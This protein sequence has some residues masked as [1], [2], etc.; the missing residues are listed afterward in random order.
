[1]S[2]IMSLRP[3]FKRPGSDFWYY[4]IDRKRRS[5][6]TKNKAEAE[7]LFNAIK[8]Q[9]MAGKIL[10]LNDEC[11]KSLGEFIDEFLEWSAD[12]NPVDTHKAH[13]NALNKLLKVEGRSVR[14][15]RVN[16]RAIDRIKA[17]FKSHKP[18]SINNYIRHLKSIFNKPVEWGYLR[19]NPFRHAKQVSTVKAPPLYLTVKDVQ[20]LL[21][22]VD[23]KD[24]RALITAY[25]CTGR[26]RAELTR[27]TWED[28]D[29]ENARYFVRQQKTHLSRWFP[30][31]RDF[32]AVLD[33]FPQSERQGFVFKRW[34]HPDTVSHVVKA[35]LKAAG[36]GRFHLH[37]LRHSFALLFLEQEGSL[38]TLQELLGHTQH[39]T[40]EIYAHISGD[41]LRD[42]VNMVKMPSILRRVK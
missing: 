10:R 24:A 28:V 22:K 18:A 37:T 9:Y 41:H 8:K 26:R 29:M 12:T 39:Q 27:L 5:L 21:G 20:T 34:R 32:M 38:R 17:E 19:A 3:P 4:E 31:S 16:L 11:A 6:G 40:T 36:L 30:A 42:A 1:M 7:R 23:D 13:E 33:S 15:D 35:A 2:L 25:L 14:L